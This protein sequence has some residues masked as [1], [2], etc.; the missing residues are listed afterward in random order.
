MK[1]LLA[2][3]RGID[4][5]TTAVGRVMFWLT[6][7]MVLIGAFNVITRYVGRAFN[8]SLGGTRYIVLQTYAYNLVFLLGAAHVF[9]RDGHVRVDILYANRSPRTKAWID[10]LGTLFFLFPFCVLGF[11][12]SWGYVMRSWQQN[13][14]N[15][16]AGGLPVYPIKTVILVAF[17]LL[18]LQGVS[19]IIKRVAVLRGYPPPATAAPADVPHSGALGADHPTELLPPERPETSTRRER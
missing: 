17:A 16:N 3:S 5:L 12:L 8:L 6:L 10:I 18:V 15:I 14:V 2:V 4:A 1:G 11:Y 19:E 7:V 9:N 13:E